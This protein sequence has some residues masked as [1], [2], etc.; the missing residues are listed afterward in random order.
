[1][2]LKYVYQGDK[3]AQEIDAIMRNDAENFSE[4]HQ[5]YI[6]PKDK[7]AQASWHQAYQ[8][9]NVARVTFL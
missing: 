4:H 2:L 7:K 3:N 5:T 1:M 6:I 8:K 9:Q